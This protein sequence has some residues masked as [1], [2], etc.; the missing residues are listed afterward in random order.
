V[1]HTARGGYHSEY[2]GIK[3]NLRFRFEGQMLKL[4]F[5]YRFGSKEIKAARNRRSG[6]EDE[7]N[8]I[9]GG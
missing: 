8:R 1:F 3:T 6:T 2:A 7:L 5:N 9:K 4:N